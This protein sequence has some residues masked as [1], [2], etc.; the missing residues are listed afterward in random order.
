M[1]EKSMFTS[2]VL[3]GFR[4]KRPFHPFNQT[5]QVINPSTICKTKIVKK[6]LL[7]LGKNA[8]LAIGLCLLFTACNNDDEAT[9]LQ[10]PAAYDGAAFETN[11]AAELRLVSQLRAITDEAKKGRQAGTKVSLDEL[12]RL[13]TTGT[14]SLK[15]TASTYYA[16]RLEGASGWLA[17]LSKASGGTY[18]PGP[19]TGEGGVFG[20]GS[21]AYLFDENGL[22]ME[23]MIEKGMF[24][25]VLYK[26]AAELLAGPVTPATVDQVVAVLGANPTFPN[27]SNAAKHPRPD[28]LMAVYAARRSDAQNPNSLYAELKNNF[29][30]LQAAAKAGDTY[31][32]ERD[33]AIAAIKTNWEKANAATVINYCHT[34]VTT[35]SR[36][37]TTDNDKATALHAYGEAVG[38][39][40][41][42]RGLP[43]AQKRITDAQIDEILVLFN[44]P[45]TGTPTSYKFI[46]DPVTELPKLT[47]AINRL[48][49][50]Y[51][52]TDA[53]IESFRNN[54]VT[55]Q[56]R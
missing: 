3:G 55:L 13:F 30:K 50:I 43:Q 20:T 2:G 46:T 29:I 53:E 48:K 14:P 26:R 33:E 45:A 8:L 5:H 15:S 18:Q 11:A 4:P 16:G 17:E 35:M 6:N 51:G 25:A 19:P 42:W 36:T 21:S 22:E 1:K 40:H 38:F 44:A 27:S 32:R 23:Q 52:F 31:Q 24:G 49:T 39:L 12:N 37:T 28:L 41:G 9:P 54:W 34:V 7:S 10:I 47:Q 56:Q